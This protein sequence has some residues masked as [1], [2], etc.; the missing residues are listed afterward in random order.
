MWDFPITASHGCPSESSVE[1]RLLYAH[2]ASRSF[3]CGTSR[4][5]RAPE[6]KPLLEVST[7]RMLGVSSNGMYVDEHRPDL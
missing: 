1:W 7:R 5:K 4:M 3:D 2:R 6:L